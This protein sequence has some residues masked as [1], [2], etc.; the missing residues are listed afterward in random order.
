MKTNQAFTILAKAG[1]ATAARI[2]TKNQSN[3][4]WL[5]VRI[6]AWRLRRGVPVAKIIHEKW[7]YGMP[8]YTNARTLDPRPDTE[9]L[10]EAVLA[11]HRAALPARVLDL[12]TGTGCL[13]AAIVK[14]LTGATGVGIDISRGAI[15]VAKRNVENLGLADRIRIFRRD[16]NSGADLGRFDIIVSN[17]PY[18]ACGDWRVNAAARHDP[19]VALYAANNGLA[20]YEAIA[21]N[22]VK[23][24]NPGGKIYLEI[25]HGQGDAV[26]GIFARNSWVLIKSFDD[27]SG[28]RRVLSFAR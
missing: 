26:R 7:F 17:P 16:F 9:T 4:S 11:E 20:A 6:M 3:L 14:N 22:A 24:I 2:I 27:L 19:H 15:R 13:I 1:G 12:G 28:T 23:W 8:F 25:G 21:E 18:I 10:V 5:A